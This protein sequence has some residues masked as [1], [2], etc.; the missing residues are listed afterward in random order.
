MILALD[1][2]LALVSALSLENSTRK[3]ENLNT[4][5]LKTRKPE[6]LKTRKLANLKTWIT[7]NKPMAEG[8]RQRGEARGRGAGGRGGRS[9]AEGRRQMGKARGRGP[10]AGGGGEIANNV[11]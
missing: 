11:F 10:A 1:L 7:E 8:R 4:Q 2:P 5:N 3:L 9:V 6:N